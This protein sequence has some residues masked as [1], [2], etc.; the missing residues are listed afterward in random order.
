MGATTEKEQEVPRIRAGTI[1]EHKELT[2]S[3]ILEAAQSLFH[4]LGYQETS[5]ADI[6]ARVGI[7]RTTLYEY[8]TDKEDLVV[9]LVELELPKLLHR[10]VEEIDPT[11]AATDQIA[12][13]A[14]GMVEFVGTDPTLGLIL[15]RDIPKLSRGAQM[16]VRDAHTEFTE[17]FARI[18]SKGVVSGELRAIPIDLAGRF[19][20]DL[21]MSAAKALIALP[22]PARRMEEV[23]ASM[24]DFL[25]NGLSGGQ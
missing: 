9:S 5:L 13:L 12:G 7:G 11:K 17:A 2:R 19:L 21:I 4:D 24:E 23:L 14:R 8:F 25:L 20:Q 1:A 6:S 18:Y 10:L 22:E 15:H 16:R 3:Q